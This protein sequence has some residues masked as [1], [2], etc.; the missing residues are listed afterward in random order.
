MLDHPMIKYAYDFSISELLANTPEETEMLFKLL[1]KTL[2]EP[3]K[4]GAFH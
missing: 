4:Q 3:K 1:L 2:N